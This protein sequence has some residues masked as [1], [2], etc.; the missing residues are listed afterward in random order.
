[1]KLT[2]L[3]AAEER[4]NHDSIEISRANH[5]Y[6][7]GLGNMPNADDSGFVFTAHQIENNNDSS[8]IEDADGETGYADVA[9]LVM[10]LPKLVMIRWVIPLILIVQLLVMKWLYPIL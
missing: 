6:E 3:T 2:S 8:D 5:Q 7:Y 9:K 10:L 1:M 4:V